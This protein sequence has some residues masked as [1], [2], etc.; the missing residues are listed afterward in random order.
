MALCGFSQAGT[1]FLLFYLPT[2][3]AT[4]IEAFK[5]IVYPKMKIATIYTF[6]YSVEQ[7]QKGF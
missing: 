6:L 3:Q 1:R 2:Q 5:G 4:A 7:K